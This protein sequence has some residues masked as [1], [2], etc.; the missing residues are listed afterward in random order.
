MET[1][2]AEEL[3]QLATRVSKKRR[4]AR[5]TRADL[6]FEAG[7]SM[8]TVERI[9]SGRPVA[10]ED[11]LAVLDAIAGAGAP[12]ANARVPAQRSAPPEESS[13]DAATA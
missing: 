7:I 10:P 4:L 6:A 9:E 11:L 5:I 13:G 8:E 1:S 3:T 2:S 12:W